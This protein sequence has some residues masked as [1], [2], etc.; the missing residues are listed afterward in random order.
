MTM[1]MPVPPDRQQVD[2][3]R[4]RPTA[5]VYGSCD[6]PGAKASARSDGESLDGKMYVQERSKE[7]LPFKGEPASRG[8]GLGYKAVSIAASELPR[9]VVGLGI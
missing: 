2:G 1:M 6:R 7:K 3:Y 4:S 5:V 9:T 8:R